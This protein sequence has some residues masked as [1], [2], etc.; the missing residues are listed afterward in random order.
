MLNIK[1][2][3]SLFLATKYNMITLFSYNYNEILYNTILTTI[4]QTHKIKIIYYGFRESVDYDYSNSFKRYN[5][6]SITIKGRYQGYGGNIIFETPNSVFNSIPYTVSQVKTEYNTIE[7]NLQLNYNLFL[8]FYRFNTTGYRQ[9]I[10]KIYKKNYNK[11]GIKT[12]QNNPAFTGFNQTPMQYDNTYTNSNEII[13]YYDI[14]PSKYGFL[15]NNGYI[16]KK[17]INQPLT[18][19]TNDFFYLC[20]KNL[21]SDVYVSQNNAIGNYII[22]AKVYQEMN[23]NFNSFYKFKS[24]DL[25][26]DQKLKSKI[27]ELE[28]FLL[29]KLGN[30]V[31]LNNL[32]YNF[33]LEIHEY[34]EKIKNIDTKNGMVF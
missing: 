28:V 27:D 33:E 8:S 29:D 12:T 2:L 14:Y 19:R 30:L 21:E 22:F 16:Y 10:D 9:N 24:Y 20:I 17:T 13:E 6:Y 32:D 15:A 26:F 7:L 34:I 5:Y 11:N 25:I 18:A 3:V 4:N 1:N 23:D 31:N